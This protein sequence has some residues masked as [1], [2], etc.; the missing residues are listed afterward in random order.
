MPKESIR[1]PLEQPFMSE[2]LVGATADRSWAGAATSP[3]L[4]NALTPALAMLVQLNGLISVLEVQ[5]RGQFSPL[6]KTVQLRLGY[7]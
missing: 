2:E 6:P 1:S 5:S 7:G 3:A 4:D